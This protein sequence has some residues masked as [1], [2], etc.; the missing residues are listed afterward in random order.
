[1]CD[2]D[3]EDDFPESDNDNDGDNDGSDGEVGGDSSIIG[4]MNEEEDDDDDDAFE[5]A[6]EG[7]NSSYGSSL[8]SIRHISQSALSRQQHDPSSA[9]ATG[10]N[11][12]ASAGA[13]TTSSWRKKVRRVLMVVISSHPFILF[14]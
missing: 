3:G 11:T 5:D 12:S 9:S 10:T 1:M 8:R 2:S 6:I 13:S 7:G 4:G 14:Y